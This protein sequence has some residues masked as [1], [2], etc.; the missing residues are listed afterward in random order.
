MDSILYMD[1]KQAVSIHEKTIKY[2]GGG[3]CASY[4]LEN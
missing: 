2:S 4:D 3:I 1:L